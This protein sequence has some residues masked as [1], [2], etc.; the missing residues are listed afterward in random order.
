MPP[1]FAPMSSHSPVC[2]PIR[3]ASPRRSIESLIAAAQ[4]TAS[5]GPSKYA[6]NLALAV[7]TI[8]PERQPGAYGIPA[9]GLLS[10]VELASVETHPLAH[11][12]ESVTA[13]RAVR[14]ALSVVD[15]LQLEIVC[16]VADTHQR[17]RPSGVLERVRQR[18]LHDSVRGEVDAG[19][20]G[21][22]VPV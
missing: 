14:D 22:W 8:A 19:R 12:R 21:A 9:L 5:V 6:K 17:M 16:P 3:T 20:Q 4:R 18:L 15:D 11:A 7:V 2:N 13:A 10:R 1:S